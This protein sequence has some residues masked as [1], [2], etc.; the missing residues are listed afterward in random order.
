VAA[1]ENVKQAAYLEQ[2]EKEEIVKR[3][4]KHR[5]ELE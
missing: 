2:L 4:H 5:K 3:K 1:V